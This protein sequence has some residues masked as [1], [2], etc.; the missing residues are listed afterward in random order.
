MEA[1]RMSRRSF[2]AATG[3]TLASGLLAACAA[4]GPGQAPSTGESGAAPVQESTSFTLWGL[5]YDPHV[6]RYNMLA[7]AFFE[8]NEVRP[9][10]EPQAWPIEVKVI[11][12][13]AADITP[14]VTCIMGKQLVPLL[15]QKA[16]VPMEEQIFEPLG[17]D[18][19]TYFNPGAIGAYLYDGRYWGV[20][21]EDNNVGMTMAV[22]TDWVDEAGADAQALLPSAQDADAIWFDSFE[23]VWNLA[24]MLQKSDSAGAV[25][26]WGMSSQGWDNRTLFGIMRELGQ[27]WWDEENEQFFLNSDQA[28]EALRIQVQVPVFDRKIETA[29]DTSH[30]DAILAGK[31]AIG[32]GNHAMSGE[33]AKLDIPVESWVRPPLTPGGTPQFVG[34]GGWGFEIPVQAKN[35]DIATEFVRFVASEEGQYIWAGIYGGVMPATPKVMTTDIYEG[36]DA[37]KRSARR[38]LTAL[39]NTVYYGSGFGIPSEMENITSTAIQQ[40]RTG[41]LTIQEA[42]EQMQS[43]MEAHLEQW[44]AS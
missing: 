3:I 43:E 18:V 1:K 6:E 36:D 5:Q 25:S 17:I 11:A 19:S 2:L 15:Q 29:L 22:R 32:F 37:V 33:A 24:E 8:K 35:L 40:A 12:A 42:A 28:I 26:V 7:D 44:K 34:E 38:D 16:I 23:S 20:P 21:V 13:M 39:A 31:I 27:M 4:P 9:T 30:I 14:D 10:I 41:E